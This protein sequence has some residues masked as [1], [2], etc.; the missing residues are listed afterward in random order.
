VKKKTPAKMRL[1]TATRV[2]FSPLCYIREVTLRHAS[3]KKNPSSSTKQTETAVTHAL[4]NSP[5][6][7]YDQKSK[8]AG[9]RVNI[10]S[11]GARSFMF[12]QLLLSLREHITKK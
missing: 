12:Q 11:G 6:S 3:P 9:A 7:A 2:F 10:S 4:L 8:S 1:M 5:P